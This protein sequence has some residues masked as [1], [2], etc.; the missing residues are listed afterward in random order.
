VGSAGGVRQGS[1]GGHPSLQPSSRRQQG[2]RRRLRQRMEHGLGAWPGTMATEEMLIQNPMKRSEKFHLR[3]RHTFG[4]AAMVLSASVAVGCWA[5]MAVLGEPS[6]GEVAL[7][8]AMGAIALLGLVLTVSLMN[9]GFRYLR[10][11][12]NE[13]RWEW[14]ASIRHQDPLS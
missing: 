2:G 9:D 10:I 7:S 1:R 4:M 3:A 12:R 11:S 14:R 13:A 5:P 6:G 8:A